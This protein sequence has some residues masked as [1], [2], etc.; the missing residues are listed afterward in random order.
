M[1]DTL[2]TV[3]EPRGVLGVLASRRKLYH[4]TMEEGV[5][6]VAHITRLCQIQ[7]EIHLMGK[8]FMQAYFGVSNGVLSNTDG[9]KKKI[10]GRE[11][12]TM[13]IDKDS[14]H[15]YIVQEAAQP[16]RWKLADQFNT[17]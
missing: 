8:K 13:L 4:N 1:W 3:K 16:T 11:V 10:T 14:D 17:V 15:A 6:I 2:I 12:A 7:N 9:K 5:K